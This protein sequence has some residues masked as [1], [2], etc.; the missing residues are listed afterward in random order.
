VA[1]LLA[2]I[3]AVAQAAGPAP[4]LA[5]SQI[6]LLALAA[7]ALP[8]FPL[9]GVYAFVLTRFPGFAA[10]GLALLLPLAG[11][12]GA[13]SVLPEL[14]A[15]VLSGIKVLALAGALYGSIKALAQARAT[16]LVAY[17]GL[18]FYSI[19]WWHLAT[20][21]RVMSKDV[22]F[23][24]AAALVVAGLCLA[25][26]ALRTRYGDLALDRIGGL[27]RP[28]PRFATLVGLLVMAAA[29]LPPFGL[30]SGFIALL[31]DPLNDVASG[32]SVA[33]V[34]V[35]L[36]WFIASWYL[37]KLMQRLLFGPH[38]PDL[39]YQDLRLAEVAP[40]VAVLLI[41]LAMGVAPHAL[42]A[43]VDTTL[44]TAWSPR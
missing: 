14:P 28:M 10:A 36:V 8:L 4:D 35:L 43:E 37:Y 3:A 12:Y 19:L 32:G 27:A 21:G 5:G 2:A 39:S 26:Q 41:L 25:W 20:A 15:G 9:H 34:I 23:A 22:I 29:G 42:M 17:G 6:A 44:L 40:L 1:A 16:G 7:V 24:G 18:A 13:G 31:F 11:L 30:F 33:M 38:R